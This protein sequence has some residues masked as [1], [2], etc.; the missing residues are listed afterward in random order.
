MA[1][2]PASLLLR[3]YSVAAPL[4]PLSSLRSS[5]LVSL[6]KVPPFFTSARSLSAAPLPQHPSDSSD[7]LDPPRSSLSA[8]LSF[9]L[10]QID[11]ID[12]DRAD[13]EAALQRIRAWHQAKA[14]PPPSPSPPL[15]SPPSIDDGTPMDPAPR[16]TDQNEIFHAPTD[17]S[18]DGSMRDV[19][20]Q[21]VEVVHPWPEWIELIERLSQQNYFD[22]RRTDEERVAANLSIDLSSIKEEVGFDFSRDWTAVRN[23]CS[24][25]GRDRFDILRSLSR[26][27]I[28]VLVGHGCPSMSPK[29]VF[30]A[31]LLRKLVHLDEGDVCSSCSLRSK[32]GR[33][34]ILPRKEDEARTLDVVRILLTFGFNHVKET[35]ENKPLMK[36]ISVKTVIRKLL[37][38]IVKL[39]AIPIDPNLPPPVIKKPPPKVKQTPP[40]PKKRVGRDDVE[41]KKGDWL[42]TKCNFMNFAKN[43]VCLQCDA[44]RPKRQ[45]LPG[46]WEC[47]KCNFLNYRRNMAC[48]HCD[49][50]RPPDEYTESQVHTRDT[51]DYSPNTRLERT[52]R[53]QNVSSAWNFDFDDNESDGADVAAFEFADPHKNDQGSLGNQSYRGTDLEYKDDMVHNDRVSRTAERDHHF[54]EDNKRKSAL[55]SRRTGFDDFDE[56]EDDDVDSYELDR[57]QA[58]EVSRMNFSELEKAS[59]SEGSEAFDHYINSKNHASKDTMSDSED[60]GT[61]EHPYWRPGHDADSD[62]MAGGRG[63]LRRR[64]MPFGSDDDF[65]SD[66]DEMDDSLG[67]RYGK[68]HQGNLGRAR[69]RKF[70]NSGDRYPAGMVSDDDDLSRDSKRGKFSSRGSQREFVASDR[71]GGR[72]NSFSRGNYGSS[73]GPRMHGNGDRY[74][75]GMV[76]D[77]DDLSGDSKRGKF[78]SRGSQREFG[79]S[80]RMGSRRNSFTRGNYGSSGGPRVHG[81]GDRFASGMVS[82]DDDYSS[83][84]SKRGQSSS[85]GSQREFGASDRM[86]SRRN[87]FSGESRMHRNGTGTSHRSF[88]ENDG[89]QRFESRR[90]TN[91]GGF[92]TLDQKRNRSGNGTRGSRRNGR[93][94][95]W[96]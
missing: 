20:R 49:H 54:K 43:I 70:A 36:M 32:C 37:H 80:D 60:E 81:N 2:S 79:A 89:F 39:S 23:A 28:Q 35:V 34:Y 82:D 56:E 61:A 3:R 71:M 18:T 31:K 84:G 12:R 67:S 50:Q 91:E 48:F 63:H 78:S 4:S 64:E 21:E 88:R 25:F 90:R 94:M 17:T 85:R 27:D 76:S 40:P 66:S 77:D 41:M 68:G 72:K 13:K 11:S 19:L 74:A 87:S 93:G 38:E 6:V 69:E 75:A 29:V 55:D 65:K 53:L 7:P 59:D 30:S 44:K 57:T 26:N 42:C 92:G 8:R 33:G 10:D 45:L 52:T 58:S 5:L 22:F 16:A 86:G 73:R 95:D 15:P 1:F 96:E 83:R 47:P 51:R 14:A 62:Q 46:E 9:V 24:N